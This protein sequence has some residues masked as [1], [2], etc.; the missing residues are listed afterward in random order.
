MV[1]IYMYIREWSV[2]VVFCRNLT[3]GFAGKV[4]RKW[5][6]STSNLD[7]KRRVVSSEAPSRV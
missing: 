3:W 5:E 7:Y 1:F 2:F 4:P 6:T